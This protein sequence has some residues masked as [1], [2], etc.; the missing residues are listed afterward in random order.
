ML[1]KRGGG[2]GGEG[3][4]EEVREGVSVCREVGERVTEGFEE[5]G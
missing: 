3:E 5:E 4:R 2:G 1:V